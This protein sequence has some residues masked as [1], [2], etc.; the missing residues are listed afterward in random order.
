[1]PQNWAPYRYGHWSWIDPWGWTWVDDAPWGF[2]PFHYGRW[3]HVSRGWCWVPGPTNVRP[4][5]A[6]A[7]VAFVGGG[8]VSLS[9]SSGPEIGWF[10][11]APREVYRPWYTASPNYMRQVNVSNTRITNV[12]VINNIISNPTAATQVNQ[13]VNLR[14]PNA[15]TAV[16]PAAMAQSQPVQRAALEIRPQTIDRSRVTQVVQ[17]APAQQA[18]VGATKPAQAKPPGPAD[19]PEGSETDRTAADARGCSACGRARCRTS[20]RRTSPPGSTRCASRHCCARGAARERARRAGRQ[21]GRERRTTC[22]GARRESRRGAKARGARGS[23]DCR[24]RCAGTSGASR[25]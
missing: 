11:L 9:V 2:A 8:N 10:P 16:P 17:V 19:A 4:V 5:Y 23:I 22:E 12:T 21:A 6:P 25:R 20:S 13:Y 18:L 15:V 7:L 14:A 3:M 1:M 24:T